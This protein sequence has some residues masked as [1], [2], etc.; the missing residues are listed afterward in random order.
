[1]SFNLKLNLAVTSA[2]VSGILLLTTSAHAVIVESNSAE[3]ESENLQSSVSCENLTTVARLGESSA[4][5]FSWQTHEFGPE[6]TPQKRCEI[7]SAK[8]D[9]A[10]QENGGSFD[11]L[12]LTNGPVNHRVVIC[13]LKPG[14]TDCNPDNLLFTLK[15]ENERNAG[16]IIGQLLNINGPAG[17]TIN[18]DSGEQVV[19]DLGKWAKDHLQK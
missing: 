17:E 14:E 16:H 13:I 15:H 18:E 3:S 2:A 5:L 7:V 1:M 4:P 8:L 12:R 11:G 9:A 6:Y 19:V 10:V